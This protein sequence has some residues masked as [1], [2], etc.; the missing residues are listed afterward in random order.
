[1]GPTWLS[2]RLHLLQV[3]GYEGNEQYASGDDMFLIEKMS[4]AFPGKIAFAKSLQATVYT[5]GKKNW[6]SFFKQRL[7]WAGKNKGLQQKAISRIWAFVGAYHIALLV[8]FVTALFHRTSSWPFLL[9][10]N[11]LLT[12]CSF[13][14]PPFFSK[15]PLSY[16][17][18]SPAILIHLLRPPTWYD[19]DTWQ[20]R[21]LGAQLTFSSILFWS[22]SLSKGPGLFVK[23]L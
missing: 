10:Q 22:L 17:I 11:G 19:D 23:Q 21:R 3:N 20:E 9:S 16:S 5:G 15:G 12:I 8:F 13:P 14:L 7:R 18:R 6:S 2:G 4:M 1:M